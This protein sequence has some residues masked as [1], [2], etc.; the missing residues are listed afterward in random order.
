MKTAELKSNIQ[1]LVDSI[2]NEQILLTLYEFLK[3]A[4]KN[5]PGKLW[6]SLTSEQKEEIL[7]AYKESED[8][9]NLTD[10]DEI[11]KRVDE[12]HIHKTS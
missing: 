2:Q 7:L 3:S 10:K 11:F 8:E 4:E 9:N 12:N 5:K 6:E 1:K